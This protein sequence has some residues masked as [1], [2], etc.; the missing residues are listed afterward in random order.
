MLMPR[1]AGGVVA[2]RTSFEADRLR[3][4]A[5]NRERYGTEQSEQASES[6]PRGVRTVHL[7]ILPSKVVRRARPTPPAHGAI[8]VGGHSCDAEAMRSIARQ[9]FFLRI[10]STC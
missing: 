3:V 10:A 9:S 4:R 1:V 8:D 2:A 6:L 5:S 7:S